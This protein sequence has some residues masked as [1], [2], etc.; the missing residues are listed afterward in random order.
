MQAFYRR[1]ISQL[2]ILRPTLAVTDFKHVLKLDPKNSLARTQLETTLKLI[3]RIE[4]EKAISV[5][6]QET[7][8]SQIARLIKDGAVPFEKGNWNGP[9]PEY[10]EK[11]G[12]YKVSRE[13]VEGMIEEFKKGGKLPKRL[14]YEIVLGCKEALVKE[15]SLVDIK[16]EKGVHCDVV[17]DTHGVSTS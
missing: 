1:A 7:A 13:F 3:R 15:K 4:F 8:S 11:E 12:R 6:D 10:D 9:V 5:G 14:V 16:I 2:A 17:G